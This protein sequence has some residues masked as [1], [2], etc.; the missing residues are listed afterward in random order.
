M[1]HALSQM[2]TN[3]PS[4]RRRRQQEWAAALHD[5]GLTLRDVERLA[6]YNAQVS[7]GILHSESYT[8]WMADLQA[9]YNRAVLQEG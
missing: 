9:R 5:A 2:W 7:G 4:A 3:R 8:A 6:E 1:W